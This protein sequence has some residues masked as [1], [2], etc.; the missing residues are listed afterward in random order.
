MS[1]LK[2]R[3]RDAWRSV[4]FLSGIIIAFTVA[5]LLNEERLFSE[6]ENRILAQ[7][8]ELTKE[9]LLSG[10]YMTD[11]EEYMND[12]F[13]SRDIWIRIKTG[14]DMLMQSVSCRG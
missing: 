13:V 1:H 4:I 2:G 5:D 10:E 12:Q 7:K 6:S 14:I 8:P 9:T 11:Y 3:R